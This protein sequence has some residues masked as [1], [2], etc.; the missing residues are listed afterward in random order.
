MRGLNLKDW[1]EWRF[2]GEGRGRGYFYK[3]SSVV[4]IFKLMV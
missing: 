1:I 4:D 3:Q 2:S